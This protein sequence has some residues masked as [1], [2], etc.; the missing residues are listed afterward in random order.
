MQACLKAPFSRLREKVPEG[1]MRAASAPVANIK[2][3][4]PNKGALPFQR[5]RIR[6]LSGFHLL[7]PVR[8]VLSNQAQPPDAAVSPLKHG[9]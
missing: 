2:A 5:P 4:L 1:R 8:P 3:P 6:V 7:S 9:V